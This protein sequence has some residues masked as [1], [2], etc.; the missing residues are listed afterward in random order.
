MK[1]GALLSRSFFL[2]RER[3]SW[4]TITADIA[5]L[6]A[7]RMIF[8]YYLLLN[9][10]FCP[11]RIEGDPD[12]WSQAT[13]IPEKNNYREIRPQPEKTSPQVIAPT[14][15]KNPSR[16]L[17][18][19]SESIM[20]MVVEAEQGVL[21]TIVSGRHSR[22]DSKFESQQ[23]HSS[24]CRHTRLL[25]C[26]LSLCWVSSC[27]ALGPHRIP[28]SICILSRAGCSIV[29]FLLS[30]NLLPSHRYLLLSLYLFTQQ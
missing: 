4:P 29:C 25:G 27:L 15:T 19:A 12:T 30:L 2:Y 21:G 28:V 17:S 18:T 20:G 10:L 14:T 5:N 24:P 3:S 1:L 11:G 6:T 16:R 7:A 13:P 26:F 9:F 23:P 8:P 22:P